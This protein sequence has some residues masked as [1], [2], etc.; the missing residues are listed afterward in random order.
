MEASILN[1]I[2]KNLGL[3]PDY[4]A[5]DLDIVIYINTVFG[6]LH[7]IGVG[8]EEGF[9]IED[10]TSTWDQFIPDDSTNPNALSRL[11]MVKTYISL[12]TRQIF[13]PPATSYMISAME[14]QIEQLE[15]RLS[16]N[17]ETTEWVD[18]NPVVIIDE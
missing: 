4:T 14:D 10:D 7:Q 1:T 18:P 2:K 5:F 12:R 8:P 11:N 9:A 3:A 17:R 16:V 15:W 6:V 13:D